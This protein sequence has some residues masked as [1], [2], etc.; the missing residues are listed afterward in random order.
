VNELGKKLEF[1]A[2]LKADGFAGRDA[3]F[4]S[5]AWI[6]ADAGLAR[7]HGEDAEAAQFD[8][9]T[10]GEGM[11]HTF[12]HLVD[13]GLRFVARQPGAFHHVVNN[14]ELDHAS[15]VSEARVNR[16]NCFL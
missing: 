3:D 10:L 1:F 4:S 12:K 8:A 13:R 9:L 7:A 5:S 6:A 16:P 11:L 14:V 15:P 2:G